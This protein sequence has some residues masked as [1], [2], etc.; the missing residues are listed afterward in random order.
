[1]RRFL[2]IIIILLSFQGV[3]AQKRIE[4]NY[5]TDTKV[6][7]DIKYEFELKTE[8]T[9]TENGFVSR[10]RLLNFKEESGD[11]IIKV[12]EN[13]G[14]R[15]SLVA[16]PY[17]WKIGE[18]AE[19][20]TEFELPYAIPVLK[21]IIYTLSVSQISQQNNSQKFLNSISASSEIGNP[22]IPATKQSINDLLRDGHFNY[23]VLVVA[24][25]KLTAGKIG[26]AQIINFNSQPSRLNQYLLPSGGT[27][28]YEYQWQLSHDSISWTD[29]SGA[30]EASYSPPA[31]TANTW[32]RLN[33]TSGNFNYES[34]DP[35][36]IKVY[37]Q[38]VAC[39]IGNSQAICYNKIPA[40]LSQVSHPSGGTGSYTYQWQNSPDSRNWLDIAGAIFSSYSPP[41]LTT[42]T[43]YRLTIKSGYSVT[44]NVILI[45][46]IPDL[47][48]GTIGS[49]QSIC[50]NSVPSAF[51][52]LLP[53]G[54]GT[55]VYNYQW[56]ISTDNISWT[57]ISGANSV[58]YTPNALTSNS[59]FRRNTN[60]STCESKAS[61]S[62][63]VSI[64]PALTSGSI[65][66]AQSICHGTASAVLSQNT[67]PSGGTGRYSYQWQR[68]P[69]NN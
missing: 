36:L 45:E 51:V 2:G 69:D 11:F 55:G 33:V 58:T 52:Q 37:P 35:I 9:V 64:L 39:T 3:C 50:Y 30:N 8:F 40:A 7:Y 62:I 16:G 61:N 63:Q 43:W 4:V 41:S 49:D 60:S 21:D 20:R 26:Q 29:I 1:M 10:I 68:S 54:G 42:N 27:G 25:T 12:S 38:L 15:K 14:V 6:S 65:G 13:S 18:T 66:T 24:Y 53:P 48:P 34:T 59:W 67:S 31:L 56:Q 22:K 23:A 46:V 57:N 28:T 44:S 47:I 19:N 32:Y 17:V 5:I